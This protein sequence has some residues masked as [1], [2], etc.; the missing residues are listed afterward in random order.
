MPDG[1]CAIGQVVY[2]PGFPTVDAGKGQSAENALCAEP[3]GE[4]LLKPQS[5]H[6]DE[7]PCAGAD[8]GLDKLMR[9]MQGAGFQRTDDPVGGTYIFAIFSDVGTG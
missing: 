7:D 5:I 6:K 3:A 4:M 1:N 9:I 8:A 2:E